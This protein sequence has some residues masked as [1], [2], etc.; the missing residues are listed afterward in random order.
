MVDRD[1]IEFTFRMVLV[2]LYLVFS[3]VRF[4]YRKIAKSNGIIIEKNNATQKLLLAMMIYEIITFIAFVFLY[5]WIPWDIAHIQIPLWLRWIGLPIG[6]GAII[7]FIIIHEALGKNFSP[8][9]RIKKE[10]TL[11]TTGPYKRI[12]HPMYV[13]FFILHIA[14]FLIVANWIIGISWIVF[15]LVII[16]IRIKPEENMMLVRFGKEYEE[17]MKRTGRFFT[18]LKKKTC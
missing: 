1:G 17:Y 11:V 3:M 5:Q 4:R 12:R 14:V 8:K 16:I 10:Q 15:L 2:S 7:Y 18:K 9:L 13:A 6:L